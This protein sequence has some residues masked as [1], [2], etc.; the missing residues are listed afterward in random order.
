MKEIIHDRPLSSSLNEHEDKPLCEQLPAAATSRK[1]QF[2][3]AL[4]QESCLEKSTTP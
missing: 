1:A 2:K 3:D 4:K